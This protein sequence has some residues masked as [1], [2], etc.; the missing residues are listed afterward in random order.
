MSQTLQPITEGEEVEG[1]TFGESA[2]VKVRTKPVQPSQKEIEEHEVTHYPYRSWCRYCVAASGRRDKHA[3]VSEDKDDEI[4]CV[5]CDY[6]FF[7]SREDEDKPEEELEKKY[8]PFIATVDEKTKCTFGDVVHR[9]GVED[10]SVK[11]MVEHIVDL[12]HPKVKLRSDG[13]KSI[14]ALLAQVAA[15]LKR[16]GVTVVPDQTPE[17]DSQAGGVQE[18]AVKTVKDKTRCLWLQFCEMHGIRAETG[19]HRHQLLP[20]A[21]RYAGQLHT[22][23]VKG[24]DGRTGWQRHKGGWRDFPRKAIRWGEK[25]QYVQGGAKMKPQLEGSLLLK[26][27][28]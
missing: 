8:T 20:W 15:E 12:G 11:V 3:S 21:V 25:V 19:N 2:P 26:V 6:G 5:A 9:K 18:A 4:A 14:K 17:G 1:D 24:A 28:S 23:T 7:T 16:K 10:W 22:R 27:S 13:E